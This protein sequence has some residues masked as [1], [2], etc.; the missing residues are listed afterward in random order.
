[1]RVISGSARGHNLKMPGGGKTRPAMDCVKGSLFSILLSRIEG[2]RFLDLFAGSGSLGI[3]ALS[4]GGAYAAF[5]D[6][7]SQCVQTIRENLEHTKLI[8]RGEIFREDCLHFVRK[9]KLEPF[10]LVCIDPPYLKGFLDPIL[11]AIPESSLFGPRTLFIIERQ[12]KDDLGFQSRPELLLF[13]ERI[14]G[15][16]VLSFFRLAQPSENSS[17]KLKIT[18]KK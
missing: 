7:S 9:R 5:V 18:S 16:T 4:R 14:F 15:D 13:D 12:K 10:D 11:A 17:E 3:E 2:C 8:S 6:N 1:M